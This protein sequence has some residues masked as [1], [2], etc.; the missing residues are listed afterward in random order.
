MAHTFRTDVIPPK[1]APPPEPS[2]EDGDNQL[3]KAREDM[4]RKSRELWKQGEKQGD[5]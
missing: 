5:G 1:K 3:E 2:R 4:L